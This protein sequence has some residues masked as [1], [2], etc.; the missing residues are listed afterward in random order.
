MSSFLFPRALRCFIT[1]IMPLRTLFLLTLLP[2]ASAFAPSQKIQSIAN[3]RTALTQLS[4]QPFE[5]MIELPGG[6]GLSAQM[7]FMPVLEDSELIEVRYKVSFGRL[8]TACLCVT[9]VQI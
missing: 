3:G 5:R 9:F 8:K 2:L 4:A 7:K 6:K 1:I